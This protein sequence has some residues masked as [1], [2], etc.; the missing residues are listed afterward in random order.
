MCGVS[1]SCSTTLTF[2]AIIAVN[3][4]NSCVIAAAAIP[5]IVATDPCIGNAA[6]C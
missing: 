3:H 5:R 1:D 2:A 4:R 6:G